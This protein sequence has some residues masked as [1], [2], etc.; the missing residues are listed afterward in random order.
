ML[1]KIKTKSNAIQSDI[2]KMALL[3]SKLEEMDGG[4]MLHD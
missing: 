2:F 1:T 3:G 4:G